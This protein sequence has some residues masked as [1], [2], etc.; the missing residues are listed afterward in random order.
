MDFLDALGYAE[1]KLEE[2]HKIISLEI[3]K[4]ELEPQYNKIKEMI[5]EIREL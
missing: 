1:K 2:K 3:A 5:K 4:K